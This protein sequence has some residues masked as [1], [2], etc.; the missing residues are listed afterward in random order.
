MA[1]YHIKLE[2]LGPNNAGC[3]NV[4]STT[5]SISPQTARSDDYAETFIHENIEQINLHQNM[6]MPHSIIDLLGRELTCI[7]L[8]TGW[9]APVIPPE[10]F[11]IP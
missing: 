7:L 9:K 3:A 10:G 4:D 8:A 5:A 1:R 11:D 6:K 2:E